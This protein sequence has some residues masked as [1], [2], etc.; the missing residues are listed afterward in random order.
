VKLRARRPGL[1]LKFTNQRSITFHKCSLMRPGAWGLSFP[2]FS[3]HCCQR[4][5]T[6]ATRFAFKS[7]LVK[8]LF[9]FSAL[10]PFRQHRPEYAAYG[11]RGAF[12][13]PKS[14]PLTGHGGL[15]MSWKYS[16]WIFTRPLS[17]AT[18]FTPLA[19]TSDGRDYLRHWGV[20]I[21]AMTPIDA[22]VILFRDTEYGGND[23]TELG[24]MYELFRDKDD[25][26]NV[27]VTRPFGM[28][29][30]E[31]EWWMVDFQYVGET[32][33]THALIT[34]EGILTSLSR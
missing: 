16:V 15:K 22:K 32:E 9:F 21:S 10:S 19:I 17:Y 29:I 4:H 2:H 12:R 3:V 34:S 31:K 6:T 30:I 23:R 26:N 18:H 27:K 24:T 20:L 5:H 33:M 7:L 8:P 11:V 25:K 1:Q 13:Y 28:A 14:L